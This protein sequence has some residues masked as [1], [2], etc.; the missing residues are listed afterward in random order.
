MSATVPG[1][2]FKL[3]GRQFHVCF[4]RNGHWLTDKLGL[5]HHH[6]LCLVRMVATDGLVAWRIVVGPFTLAWGRF[7]QGVEDGKVFT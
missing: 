1:R 2:S 6:F 4:D 7:N 3:F 5:K